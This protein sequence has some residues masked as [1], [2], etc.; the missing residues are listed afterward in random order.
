MK[1]PRV[2]CMGEILFDRFFEQ[3]GEEWKHNLSWYDF[4]GGAPANTACAL[5]KLGVP[6][7]FIGCIAEDERGEFLVNLLEDIG[8][9]CTEVQRHHTAPTRVV[10]LARNETGSFQFV[11]FGEHD[12]AEFADAYLYAELISIDLFQEIEWLILGTLELAYPRS[13]KAIYKAV[14]LA[15]LYGVEIFVDVNWEPM[16]WKDVDIAS[17]MIREFIRHATFL[18]VTVDEAKFLFGTTKP[19]IIADSIGNLKGVLVTAGEKG[20]GYF[21]GGHEGYLTA[22]SVNAQDTTGAGDAFNAGIIYQLLNYGIS[23]LADSEITKK[24]VTYAS[25]VGALTTMRLGSI[26]SQPTSS[27]VEAFLCSYL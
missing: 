18:K 22:F 4:P 20:C 3:P 14:E 21:L 27:E 19:K 24:I 13:R 1:Q 9:N 8:V 15:K 12:S 11:G 10:Y 17:Q 26:T 25:A 16:F 5:V 2:I 7:A 6:T 23:S